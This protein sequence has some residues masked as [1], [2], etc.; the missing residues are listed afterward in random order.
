LNRCLTI[1]F[2]GQLLYQ[3]ARGSPMSC[4]CVVQTGH[5]CAHNIITPSHPSCMTGLAPLRSGCF[6]ICPPLLILFSS[7]FF[8][9]GMPTGVYTEGVILFAYRPSGP[10]ILQL[11]QKRRTARQLRATTSYVALPDK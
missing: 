8:L 3:G 10:L 2:S 11:Q 5:V 6:H 9:S 4:V 1:N 7:E